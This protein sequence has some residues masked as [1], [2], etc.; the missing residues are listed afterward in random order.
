MQ[1]RRRHQ[2]RRHGRRLRQQVRRLGRDLGHRAVRWDASGTAATE[3]GNLGTDANGVTQSVAVAINDAGTAV[4]YADKYDDSGVCLGDRAVRWDASGTAATE[5]GNLGTDIGGITDEP[6]SSPSTTP[7]SPSAT[8]MTTT[9]PAR[10]S[11]RGRS[12]GVAYI[13]GRSRRR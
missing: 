13:A 8:P 12:T 4:G 11:A 1:L 3:L 5:L 10:I 7:A 6:M 9:T 2:R